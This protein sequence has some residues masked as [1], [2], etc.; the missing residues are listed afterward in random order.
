MEA[1]Y[2]T[3]LQLG[4]GA[5]TQESAAFCELIK[6]AIDAKASR[7]DIR[8]FDEK[9][10]LEDDGE[11]IDED[12]FKIIGSVV[13]RSSKAGKKGQHGDKGIGRLST[14]RLGNKVVLSTWKKNKIR[15]QTWNW[16]LLEKQPNH[17][18]A[19][20]N[21]VIKYEI[22]NESKASGTKIEIS[23]L[24]EEWTLEKIDTL[25]EDIKRLF[26]FLSEGGLPIEI[27]IWRG[28]DE[29][30]ID[31]FPHQIKKAAHASTQATFRYDDSTKSIKVSSQIT[32]IQ[33]KV[34]IKDNKIN[35]ENLKRISPRVLKALK[36][37]GCLINNDES[38][39]KN[40]K[41]IG[42]FSIEV[43]W[44][45]RQRLER[46]D[47]ESVDGWAG[48]CLFRDSVLVYPLGLPRSD[49]LM[50]D[51]VGLGGKGYTFNRSQLIGTIRITKDENEDIKD[52]TSREGLLDSAITR[53]FYI[54]L[55]YFLHCIF[56]EVAKKMT[57]GAFQRDKKLTLEQ[58]KEIVKE[59]I[60]AYQR[61]NS[62][63]II[64]C[65]MIREWN[66]PTHDDEDDN[67]NI[68]YASVLPEDMVINCGSRRLKKIRNELVSLNR[69]KHT[70][71]GVVLLRVFT[72]L[73]M[74]GYLKR[75]GLLKELI[76]EIKEKGNEKRCL[77]Y[78]KPTMPELRNKTMSVMEQKIKDPNKIRF[79]RKALFANRKD[80]A[81][82][83]L[84]ELN[85]F[86]HH[87]DMPSDNDIEQFWVRTEPMFRLMQEKKN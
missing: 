26:D 83:T 7:I 8:F 22:Y 55:A 50:L 73:S 40:L 21:P 78:G 72:E 58:R 56:F 44:F 18:L 15:H 12:M 54:V 59:N 1:T 60:S 66:P 24:L 25:K 41:K 81:R 49:W 2:N 79:L 61:D 53:T 36:K 68:P 13:S 16:S 57:N 51:T 5:V 14:Q 30:K 34:K 35:V 74:L 86:V 45:N 32:V 10:V 6:N 77:S 82:F 3:L 67:T 71:A 52:N 19:N 9:I 31:R 27:Y 85:D 46:G 48:V 76:E 65:M 33:Q 20:F 29:E 62:T 87:D 42:N 38:I 84:D 23:K 63:N 4:R 64:D 80:G 11:G 69:K 70:N 17:P 43:F 75:I 37:I 28:S 47:K 39:E